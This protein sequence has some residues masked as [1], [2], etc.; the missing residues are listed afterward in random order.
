M[1]HG[2]GIEMA[3][4]P[5]QDWNTRVQLLSKQTGTSGNNT[6]SAFSHYLFICSNVHVIMFQDKTMPCWIIKHLC[7]CHP[8]KEL[9]RILSF[10]TL[11]P[12]FYQGFNIKSLMHEGFKLNVWDIGGQKSIRPYWCVHTVFEWVVQ[13]RLS[14]FQ[15]SLKLTCEDLTD[16]CFQ[17]I[18]E[19]Q[20]LAVPCL[21][22][23]P[24]WSCFCHVQ[25][26]RDHAKIFVLFHLLK[27]AH[28]LLSAIFLN[29]ERAQTCR[30]TEKRLWMW[31]NLP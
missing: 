2:F 5:A 19:T 3:F 28:F 30:R 20:T 26:R 15:G 1:E 21:C 24:D 31:C 17:F 14:V 16:G 4:Q 13:I 6:I 22:V 23:L 9:P 7:I 12:C 18:T 8:G 27:C 25:F 10:F 11:V 29:A